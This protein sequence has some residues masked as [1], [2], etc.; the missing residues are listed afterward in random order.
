MIAASQDIESTI[1]TRAIHP[2]EGTLSPDVARALLEIQLA[3]EDRLRMSELADR[4]RAGELTEADEAWIR[5][6]ERVGSLLGILQS[7]ARRTLN[8]QASA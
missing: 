7:K 1:L 5:G 8:R 2:E 4:A 6:Y 3:E